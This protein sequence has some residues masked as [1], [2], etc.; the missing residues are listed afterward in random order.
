[1]EKKISIHFLF[2]I[3]FAGIQC[4]STKES[5]NVPPDLSDADKIE[6][7]QIA[8]KGQKL[9]RLHCSDCHGKIYKSMD[10]GPE[11]T[12]EQIK[13]YEIFMR[14]R[15]ETHAFT[16]KMNTQDLDAI[17]IYLKYRKY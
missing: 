12:Q 4:G 11:F 15:N 17:I 9:Y 8:N 2:F 7:V 5:Y 16:Q 6:L 10:Q 14:I 13:S 1:M 3:A